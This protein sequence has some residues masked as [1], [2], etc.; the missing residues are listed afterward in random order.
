MLSPKH[1]R[2]AGHFIGPGRS[3]QIVHRASGSEAV[4]RFSVDQGVKLLDFGLAKPVNPLSGD[5]K[6]QTELTG[7]GVIAGTPRYSSPEQITGRPLDARSDLFAAAAILF[8]ALAGK[9]A[10]GGN[11][12]V[13]IFTP[14]CTKRHR[15]SVDRRPYRR[16]IAS[17]A[18]R[19]IRILESLRFRR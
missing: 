14:C 3:A 2:Y 7:V 12:S 13:E 19:W 9:P 5:G 6:T 8:E 1:Y 17:R 18:E 16:W 15:R 11:S 10:F 4:Q